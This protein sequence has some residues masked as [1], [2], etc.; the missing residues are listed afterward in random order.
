[1]KSLVLFLLGAL[2]F[3]AVA[4]GIGVSGGISNASHT[5]YIDFI[6]RLATR[7][8]S[9]NGGVLSEVD[10]RNGDGMC[11]GYHGWLE[12]DFGKVPFAVARPDSEK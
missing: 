7:G 2:L 9:Q 11:M 4:L 3:G 10:L 1:M 12:G 6:V 5:V 8:D